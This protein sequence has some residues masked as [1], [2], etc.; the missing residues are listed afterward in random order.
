MLHTNEKERVDLLDMH[1]R[2]M[3]GS[4]DGDLLGQDPQMIAGKL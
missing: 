2:L 1:F 3:E 4:E